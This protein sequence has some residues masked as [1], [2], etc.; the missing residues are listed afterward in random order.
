[1]AKSKNNESKDIRTKDGNLKFGHIHKDQV[2]SSI[3]MQGQEGLEFVSIDQTGPRKGWIWNRSKGRYQI[4]TG[5]EVGQEQ[6]AIYISSAGGN[7]QAPGNIE[8]FSKGTI[9]I[10]AENIELIATGSSNDSGNI[11]LQ[12]NQ[13]I[14]LDGGKE[15]KIDSKESTSITAASDLNLTASSMKNSA[16]SFQQESAASATKKPN[17]PVN[18]TSDFEHITGQ[19]FVTNAESKPE[20]LGRGEGRVD[21]STYMIG[22]TQIGGDGDYS[23]IEATLMISNLKNADCD[24]PENALY[25]KGNITHEGD[26]QHTGDYTHKGDMNHKGDSTHEGCF[27]VK[28]PPKCKSQ[29][30][31]DIN[32]TGSGYFGTTLDGTP[33]G[34]LEAR[35]AVA[36][37]LPVK[38]FDIPHPSREGHR[39]RHVCLEG[40]EVGVYFR[41]RVKNKTEIEL[42]EYWKDLVDET[43]ITV[44]LQAIGAHQDVIIKRMGENKIFLQAKGGMPIDCFYHVYGE[45]KDVEKLIVEYE[46]QSKTDYPSRSWRDTYPEEFGETLTLPS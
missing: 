26:T 40:P 16:G 21:G 41:G 34:R 19:L 31:G 39:L 14:K 9:K 2:I 12:G 27:T 13:N 4:V 46:G 42:P 22:P 38:P 25:V 23:E 11:H 3:M 8:M 36:D 10:Q 33:T 32:C 7:G 37:S 43:T 20:A 45:R 44:Q 35:I 17:F 5:D 24:T 15:I 30:E 18:G 6:V 29:F 1:M 28:T